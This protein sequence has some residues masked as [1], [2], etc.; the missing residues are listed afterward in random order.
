MEKPEKLLS[1]VLGSALSLVGVPPG[2]DGCQ[3]LLDHDF[4]G[5]SH[6]VCDL[7]E[8]EVG[9]LYKVPVPTKLS[10]YRTSVQVSALLLAE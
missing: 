7:L 1:S 8:G 3:H 9:T 2:T 4:A 6:T 5:S 10:L